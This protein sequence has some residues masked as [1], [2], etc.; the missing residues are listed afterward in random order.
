MIISNSK[1]NS[2]RFSQYVYKIECHFEILLKNMHFFFS[3][4]NMKR[5]L[6]CNSFDPPTRSILSLGVSRE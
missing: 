4:V 6:A 5:T 3:L 2:D 1:R